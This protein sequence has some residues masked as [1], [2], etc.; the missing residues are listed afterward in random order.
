MKEQQ[1]SGPILCLLLFP[2][3]QTKI[4]PQDPRNRKQGTAHQQNNLKF[5]Y[6]MK[7]AISIKSRNYGDPPRFSSRNREIPP[8]SCSPRPNFPAYG[9]TPPVEKQTEHQVEFREKPPDKVH[10][11]PARITETSLIRENEIQSPSRTGNRA[12]IQL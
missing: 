5:G 9:S 7:Q 11:N 8:E 3:T 6:E 10:Q 2:P 4:P 1:N 12:P